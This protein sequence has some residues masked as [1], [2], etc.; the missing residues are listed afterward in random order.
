[1]KLKFWQ[2]EFEF[3]KDDAQIVIPIILLLL[4]FA[5]PLPKVWMLV[6]FAVYYSILFFGGKLVELV[7]RWFV[8]RSYRCPYCKSL[9]TIVLGMREYLGDCPYY[10]YKCN[11]CGQESIDVDGTLVEPSSGSV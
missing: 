1:M 4:S 10:F 6:G 11:N 2:G 9:Y 3:D 5:T 8:K 7:K